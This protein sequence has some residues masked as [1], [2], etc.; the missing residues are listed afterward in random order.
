MRKTIA[1]TI[2]EG[3]HGSYANYPEGFY[4][5]T[6]LLLLSQHFGELRARHEKRLRKIAKYRRNHKKRK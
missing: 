1:Q 5:E 3:R 4:D 6:D 2:M